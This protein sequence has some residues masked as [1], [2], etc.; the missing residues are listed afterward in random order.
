M[1]HCRMPLPRS[2]SRGA[3]RRHSVLHCVP[4]LQGCSVAVLQ[5]EE[6]TL[7]SESRVA[8]R[9]IPTPLYSSPSVYSSNWTT[10]RVRPSSFLFFSSF[11]F[12][13]LFLLDPSTTLF[14]NSRLIVLRAL[15]F[16][17]GYCS[18]VQ[19]L[20][21]WFEVDLG[22]PE[23]FLG[24]TTH[25]IVSAGLDSSHCE[26]SSCSVLVC[27]ACEGIGRKRMRGDWE[28]ENARG[29]GERDLEKN[30]SSG[31]GPAGMRRLIERKGLVSM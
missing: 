29:L 2:T 6:D 7:D 16:L 30:E 23:L 12:A 22:F 25:R 13:K 24:A 9:A 19:G 1:L 14:W 4:V 3:W 20:L 28:K 8:C 18:I 11:R 5:C 15:A 10:T 31:V 27:M 17:D 21:D 26:R